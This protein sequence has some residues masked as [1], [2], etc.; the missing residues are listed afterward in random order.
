MTDKINIG[1]IEIPV[2]ITNHGFT[3]N[4]TSGAMLT[5]FIA[6]ATGKSIKRMENMSLSE[7]IDCLKEALD[8]TFRL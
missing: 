8:K 1:T 7:Y 2:E 3:V 6:S 4:I 5:L